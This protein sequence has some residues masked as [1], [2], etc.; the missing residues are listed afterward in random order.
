MN[1]FQI[2]YETRLQNWHDLKEE[3]KI[4]ETHEK[5]IKIDNWWQNA[6]LINHYLHTHDT[7][8]W[9]NPWELLLENSYCYVA[10]ALGMC[11]TLHLTGTQDI[12][13]VEAIDNMGN[14]VV[15]VLVD[16]AKYILNYWP[17]TVVNNCLQD[18]SI[19]RTIDIETLL[20][21]L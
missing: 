21:K 14:D 1:V 18:F 20:K 8:T 19:K 4:L 2:D 13:L 15:L 7:T 16:P 12:S 17:N 3:V 9:P 11:Y 6:P 10:R 5:C